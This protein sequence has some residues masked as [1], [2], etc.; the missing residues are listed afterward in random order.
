MPPLAILTRRVAL[1]GGLAALAPAAAARKKKRRR[2]RPEPAPEP[3][4]YLTI[5]IQGVSNYAFNGDRAF[6]WN[7]D[8]QLQHP[9]SGFTRDL[10]GTFT[11]T[12][13]TAN[14]EETRAQISGG[15]RSLSRTF[16]LNAGHDV[17]E[18]RIAVV[19]L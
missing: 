9:A 13:V 11:R 3:L 6:E 15:A 8:A 7:Y 10:S 18:D 2:P 19:L 12:A 17:P 4:A 5:A 1:A 16:L 14:L